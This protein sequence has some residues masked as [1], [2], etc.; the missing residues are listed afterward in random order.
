MISLKVIENYIIRE[1]N[2]NPNSGDVLFVKQLDMANSTFLDF[3]RV[4]TIQLNKN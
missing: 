4:Q 3:M 1:K 2:E